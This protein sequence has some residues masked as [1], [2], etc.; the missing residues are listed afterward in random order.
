MTFLKV[1]SSVLSSTSFHPYG[2]SGNSYSGT[3][4]LIDASEAIDTALIVDFEDDFVLELELKE[5]LD[6]APA[7]VTLLLTLLVF[8]FTVIEL[9]RVLDWCE[10]WPILFILSIVIA[11][12]GVLLPLISRLLETELFLDTDTPDA[13]G[14]LDTE[15]IVDVLFLICWSCNRSGSD[16]SECLLLSPLPGSLITFCLP[17][18]FNFLRSNPLL[19]C[20]CGL[21]SELGFSLVFTPPISRLI[22]GHRAIISIQ[23][24]FLRPLRFLL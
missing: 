14:L 1:N 12:V 18:P 2:S 15:P 8:P 7:L 3:I 9:G 17:V 16:K 24:F 20:A 23:A 4:L 10:T 5:T 19:A 13:L 6:A 22:L 21:V 11:A